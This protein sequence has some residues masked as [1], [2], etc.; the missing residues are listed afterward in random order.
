[1]REDDFQARPFWSSRR[2]AEPSRTNVHVYFALNGVEFSSGDVTLHLLV[3]FVVLPGMQPRRE[4]SAPFER[5]LIDCTLDF[6]QAHD[7]DLYC[8][9]VNASPART[10]GESL[11]DPNSKFSHEVERVSIVSS[12]P[13]LPFVV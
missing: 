7:V 5:E 2:I 13:F 8:H 6:R 4:F 3:P 1:V 10:K 12:D 9:A 11:L